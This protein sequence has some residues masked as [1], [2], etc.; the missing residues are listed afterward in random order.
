MGAEDC[1]RVSLWQGVSP[2]WG[3]GGFWQG[4]MRAVGLGDAELL[5]SLCWA[6]ARGWGSLQPQRCWPGRC[7][8][9]IISAD[10]FFEQSETVSKTSIKGMLQYAVV[11]GL[12]SSGEPASSKYG[13][14]K[15]WG[16][17]LNNPKLT[18]SKP[19]PVCK[20]PSELYELTFFL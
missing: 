2:R 19:F 6:H 14:L 15:I 5:I 4:R 1:P 11:L 3:Q 20:Y 10:H 16:F 7:S 13:L 12:G 9:H 8:S 18:L 17:F